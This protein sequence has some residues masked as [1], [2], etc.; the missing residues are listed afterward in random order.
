MRDLPTSV[1]YD[2]YYKQYVVAPKFDQ[3]YKLSPQIA[4][5]LVDTGV[6]MGQSTAAKF[7]QQAL[8]ALNDGASQYPDLIVDGQL[9]QQSIS[10]LSAYLGKRKDNG[11][12]V[13][14][15]ALNSL[16]CARYISIAESTP[17]NERFLYGWI[18]NRV[19]I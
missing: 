17:K 1:A 2:I 5:E 13:M 19:G 12:V 15:R 6:N 8:N 14:L 10:A 4:E 11:I 9:G 18:L 16:Q 7:L 3:V